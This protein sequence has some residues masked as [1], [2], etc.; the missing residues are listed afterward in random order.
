MRSSQRMTFHHIPSQAAKP[1]EAFM[2]AH[3][4]EGL[5]WGGL[6]AAAPVRIN[7]VP[8]AACLKT[9]VCWLH[10]SLSSSV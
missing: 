6:T 9:V 7:P 2:D 3:C 1:P 10:L 8:E 4:S 5:G